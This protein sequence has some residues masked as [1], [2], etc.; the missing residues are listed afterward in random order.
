MGQSRFA[1]DYAKLT[2]KQINEYEKQTDTYVDD[3]IKALSAAED[4]K[5]SSEKE[6]VSSQKKESVPPNTK[7][8][9]SQKKESV[10]QSPKKK[11]SEKKQTEKSAPF[12]QKQSSDNE[13]KHSEEPAAYMQVGI[14]LTEDMKKF[15]N[16]EVRRLQSSRKLYM[17]KLIEKAF[18]E[19][20]QG[21]EPNAEEM[22]PYILKCKAKKYP[23]PFEMKKIYAEKFSACAALHFMN[24]SE[25][26]NYLLMREINKSNRSY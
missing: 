26:C 5:N 24:K 16:R 8:W 20:D 10:P 23:M 9:N 4:S 15:L 22:E 13:R 2:K 19:M 21:A 14:Y 12:G 25:F 7:E 11:H 1:R 18:E 6:S 17:E 3:M